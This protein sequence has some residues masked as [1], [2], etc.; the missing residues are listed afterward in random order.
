M[1]CLRS[2]PQVWTFCKVSCKQK[3]GSTEGQAATSDPV[4]NA[5]EVMM[6]RQ[7]QLCRPRVP[8]TV[9]EKNKKDKLSNDLISLLDSKGLKWS[10][11]EVSSGKSFLATLSSILCYIDGHEETLS[12]HGCA[13]PPLYR[14]FQGYNLPEMSKYR[15]RTL[16]NLSC[17]QIA[18]HTAAL[19]D[20]LLLSWMSTNKWKVIKDAT[21]ALAKSLDV[22]IA[23]LKQAKKVREHHRSN[24]LPVADKL[25]LHFY[26]LIPFLI[27]P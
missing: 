10:D 11:C 27:L 18:S 17:D 4:R 8:E 19:Y 13:I 12:S 1:K 14:T 6:A 21:Q 3:T 16:T 22:Y 7:L 15:K 26:P 9:A 20:V 2:L 5:F 24:D 23:Y 25:W